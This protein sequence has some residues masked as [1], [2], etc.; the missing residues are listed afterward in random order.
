MGKPQTLFAKTGITLTIA[1]VVFLV[2]C[3]ATLVINIF[4]PLAKQGSDDLAAL[5]VLSARTWVE[6]P[7]AT[8]PFFETELMDEYQLKISAADEPLK[9]T[10]SVLP[11]LIFL[12]AALEKRI[13]TPVAIRSGK[14]ATRWFCVDIPMG[15]RFIRVS[16]PWSRVGAKPPTAVILVISAG[17]IMTLLTSLLLVRRLTRPLARLSAATSKIGRGEMLP[18]LPESGPRELADLTHNFNRMAG[19]LAELLE[20][21]TTLLAGISHD[22]RTPLTRMQLS[23]EMLLP[24]EKNDALIR[25]LRR[26]MEE[27]NQLIGHAL[28]LARGLE[29]RQTEEVDLQEFIDGVIVDYKQPDTV[30]DWE[31]EGCCL[32]SVDTMALQRI[33][34][35]LF[36]NAVRYGGNKPVAVQ[37][38]CDAD[39][40]IIKV[41]DRGE[42]IPESE[43]EAVFRPFHRLETSRCKQTGGSGLGLAIARQLSEAHGWMIELLPREGGGT[44]ARVQV[45]LH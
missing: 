42:G 29:T 37:C 1:T 10:K 20:N 15:G 28:E 13:G 22:L 9:P 45:P 8:R 23:L 35:N 24:D 41:L 31:P 7:P 39:N 4:I 34:V 43:R 12:A 16:F 25:G 30:I 33:L 19:E 44:E 21:R 17:L 38:H 14:E 36:D 2:F 11:Y 26:D 3:I 18:P 32:C 40:A 27:M 5:M 6:L